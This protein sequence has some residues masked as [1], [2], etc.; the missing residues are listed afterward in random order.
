MFSKIK[1][2]ICTWRLRF[3][4]D[5]QDIVSLRAFV[6][7]DCLFPRVA[8]TQKNWGIVFPDKKRCSLTRAWARPCFNKTIQNN[9]KQNNI[10]YSSSNNNLNKEEDD[11]EENACANSLFECFMNEKNLERKSSRKHK[12]S[13][14]QGRSTACS[15]PLWWWRR[16]RAP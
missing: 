9:T 1:C 8:A 5:I 2:P 13:I 14:P 6:S 16:C 10:N 3:L 15:C 11:K 12:M 7:N 4:S